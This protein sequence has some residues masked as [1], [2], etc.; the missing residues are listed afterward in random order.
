MAEL[1][2]GRGGRS[3]FLGAGDPD[4]WKMLTTPLLTALASFGLGSV[5]T[6]LALV[7]PAP[8]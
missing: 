4:T 8:T 6:V 3:R 7:D 5:W 2:S 1:E